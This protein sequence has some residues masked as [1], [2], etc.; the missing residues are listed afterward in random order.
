MNRLMLSVIASVPLLACAGLPFLKHAPSQT[1]QEQTRGAEH[2]AQVSVELRDVHFDGEAVSGRLLVG[3]TEGRLELD[4]RL[5]ENIHLTTES[6]AECGTGRP[7][8]HIVMD[9]LAPP[10]RKEELMELTPGYWYGKEIRMSLFDGRLAAEQ[11]P[12]CVDAEFGF[13]AL[14]R[15]P[16]ARLRVQAVRPP[17]PSGE[18]EGAGI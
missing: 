1:G 15:S 7:L 2:P 18:T 4:A 10:P 13:R 17:K 9:V 11:Q 14:G 8:A 6:V 12:V 16:T 5:I 3:L